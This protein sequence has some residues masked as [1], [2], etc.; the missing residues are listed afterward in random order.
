MQEKY[1]P[2][3]LTVIA[4]NLDE[5]RSD[6]DR[7][8]AS[9]PAAFR[10]QFDPGVLGSLDLDPNLNAVIAQFSYKFRP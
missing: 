2:L 8:L 5:G 10:I 9:T 4:V 3:G 7:F 1:G 6:A